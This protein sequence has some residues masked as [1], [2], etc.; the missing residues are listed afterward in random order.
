MLICGCVGGALCFEIASHEQSSHF[1]GSHLYHASPSC[2]VQNA[3]NLGVIGARVPCRL[4]GVRDKISGSA[5][6]RGSI[7]TSLSGT[8]GS[9]TGSENAAI[10]VATIDVLAK[11]CANRTIVGRSQ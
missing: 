10:F 11:V 8:A 2:H 5:S 7:T 6:A 3:I 1:I 9:I 4:P